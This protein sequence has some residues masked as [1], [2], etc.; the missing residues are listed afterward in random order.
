M[1]LPPRWG[2]CDMKEGEEC[3]LRAVPY[4]AS[5][6]ML[7]LTGT[8]ATVSTSGYEEELLGISMCIYPIPLCDH[9]LS[10]VQLFDLMDHGQQAPLSLSSP[11]K[12]VAVGC[13]SFYDKYSH[14]SPQT[15]SLTNIA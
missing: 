2:Q 12:N 1:A 3:E 5:F 8:A 9:P 15:V 10:H 6:P 14:N 13:H 7:A 11:C 4:R